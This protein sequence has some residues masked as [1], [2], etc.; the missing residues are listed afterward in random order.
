MRIITIILFICSQQQLFAQ[1]ETSQG[2][3]SP[4]QV[5]DQIAQAKKESLQM[6]TEL[7][8]E[9]AEATKRGDDPESII[10]M[11]KQLAT[12]KKMT[13]VANKAANIRQSGSKNIDGVNS[14]R[15]YKSPYTRFFKQAVAIPAEA[16]AKDKLLWY[17]GKKINQTTL[18]TTGGRII[19]YDRQNNRV[20]VQ[21]N[22]K[23]D[24][25]FLKIVSG[26][27]KSRQWTNTYVNNK[28]AE[29]NSFFDYPLVKLVM[30]K[31]ELIEKQFDKIAN[32]RC[33]LDSM[34]SRHGPGRA[35]SRGRLSRATPKSFGPMSRRIC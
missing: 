14:I 13:G 22:E 7:E 35:L 2:R 30:K 28:S 9:I 16:Q 10:E 6:I 4:K 19:Q 20:M 27:S 5:Q 32:T 18:V 17:R 29:K 31:Y 26:L 11:K 33:G 12:L 15:P 34:G 23:K 3:P 24:T 21:Y 8:K 1:V 25:P